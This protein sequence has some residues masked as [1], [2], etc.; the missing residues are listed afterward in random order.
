MQMLKKDTEG[1]DKFEVLSNAIVMMA[2]SDYINLLAHLKPRNVP[3][4][5]GARP[6]IKECEDFFRSGWFEG[7][8][9]VDGEWFMDKCKEKAKEL[10]IVYTVAQD[11][12]SERWYICKATDK[13]T[14]ISSNTYKRKRKALEHAAIAQGLDMFTYMK[15]RKRDKVND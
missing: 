6:S 1:L 8:T 15:I 13:A 3:N 7:L 2:A 5:S 11:S 9:G 4:K 12:E 14:P 10:V